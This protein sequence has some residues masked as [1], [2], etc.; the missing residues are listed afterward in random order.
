MF[1]IYIPLAMIMAGA[2]PLA[3]GKQSYT[4]PFLCEVHDRGRLLTRL[5]IIDSLSITRGTSNLG[6][7]N[8]G[9]AMSMEI[10]FSVLDLSSIMSMPIRP[11]FSSF[12]LI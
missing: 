10:S 1:N 8:V 12:P 3:T 5:G 7:N 4:S 9:K 11:S 2:L 6:F